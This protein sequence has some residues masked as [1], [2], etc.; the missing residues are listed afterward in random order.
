MGIYL[1]CNIRS[2]LEVLFSRESNLNFQ[3][4]VG[5]RNFYVSTNLVAY[6]HLLIIQ[7]C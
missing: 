1:V 4:G 7:N 5:S 3:L 2:D 6:D